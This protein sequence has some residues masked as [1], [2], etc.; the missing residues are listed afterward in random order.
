MKRFL[1]FLIITVVAAITVAGATMLLRA[2]K[3]EQAAAIKPSDAAAGSVPSMK[4]TH[5]RGPANAPVTL[6]E[7]GDFQCPA[8]A[9]TADVIRTVEKDYPSE[10]RGVFWQFPL[11]MHEHGRDAALAAEA[12]SRQGH[13]W[14]MHDLLYREQATWKNLPDVHATFEKFAEQLKLNVARFRQDAASGV[15][16]VT[17]DAEH[18][19]GESRGVKSTPTL[20][21]NGEEFPPPFT[22]ERLHTAIDSALAAKKAP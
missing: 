10:L 15:S 7:F 12:A 1:P 20:F 6:E 11:P 4:P 9:A 16:G 14:E 21:V 22:V 8:C 17:V 18:K 13:F 5:S 19:Y 3:R 2:K